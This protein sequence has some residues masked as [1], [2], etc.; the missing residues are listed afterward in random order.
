MFMF[1]VS[2][3]TFFDSTPARIAS[4][5]V[6][7]ILLQLFL[8]E[9]LSPIIHRT[10]TRNE[11][12]DDAHVK[13]REDTLKRIFRTAYGAAIWV[14]AIIIILAELHI[15]LAALATGAGIIGVVVGF[16]AQNTI[17]DILAGIFIII[18]NQYLVGD[19]VGLRISTGDAGIFGMVEDI[20]IR[21]TRLRDLDG[22]LHTIPNGLAGV[23]TNMSY[24]F[25]N[26]NIN[27]NVPYDTDL[28]K[29]KKAINRVGT[30]MAASDTWKALTI[31]PIQF[32]R[33]DSFND[34]S[35]TLKALGKVVPPNQ[36][37]MSA[38]F[39]DRIKLA[40]EKEG[41]KLAIPQMV[42]HESKK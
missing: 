41:I 22:N 21:V 36:W 39:R 16:G 10:V 29:A 20:T 14:V 37:N 31:E 24:Q 35:V 30:E 7:A 13:K 38:D 27:I 12:I 23:V 40:F 42:V 15:N 28:D 11:R 4:T 25:A 33:V 32:Y 17:R 19:I 1:A 2:V 8:R 34:Y 3:G 26:A 5:I 18:E 6:V 9:T